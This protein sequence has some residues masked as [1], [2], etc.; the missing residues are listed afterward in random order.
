MS[1]SPAAG[2]PPRAECFLLFHLF[3]KVSE[4]QEPPS[5]APERRIL[6]EYN[7]SNCWKNV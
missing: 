1:T 3:M 2:L 7:Y 5:P 6:W 4:K